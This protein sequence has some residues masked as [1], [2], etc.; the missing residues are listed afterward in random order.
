MCDKEFNISL[1]SYF[2]SK[3]E[4]SNIQCHILKIFNEIENELIMHFNFVG[5]EV[6][7]NKTGSLKIDAVFF[8]DRAIP[9]LPYWGIEHYTEDVIYASVFIKKEEVNENG[10]K[11][12]YKRMKKKLELLEKHRKETHDS[13]NSRLDISCSGMDDDDIFNSQLSQ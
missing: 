7:I 8:E 2:Q 9:T 6:K 5:F 3:E 12:A 11:K 4:K 1:N 13:N 10:I